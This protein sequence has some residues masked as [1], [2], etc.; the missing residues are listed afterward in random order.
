MK[1]IETDAG[2][3]KGDNVMLPMATVKKI[4]LYSIAGG[5]NL[6]IYPFITCMNY[7]YILYYS[8]VMGGFL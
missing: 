5:G 3:L 6:P 1:N 4:S 8:Y 2:R 7:I